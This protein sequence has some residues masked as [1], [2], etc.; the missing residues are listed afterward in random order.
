MTFLRLKTISIAFTLLLTGSLSAQG[1]LWKIVP[2]GETDAPISYLFGTIHT[3][4]SKVFEFNQDVLSALEETDVF[5]P[6]IDP[7]SLKNPMLLMSKLIMEDGTTLKDL[8]NEDEYN[9]VKTFFKDSLNLPLVMVKKIQPAF[10]AAMVTERTL[11]DNS[12]MPA[13]DFWLHEQAKEQNKEVIALETLNEQIAAFS[14]IDYQSQADMLLE[15]VSNSDSRNKTKALLDAYIN[16][17]LE[18]LKRLSEEQS[19]DGENFEEVF[20]VKRNQN[21]AQRAQEIIKRGKSLFI[22]VGAAHLPGEN[23]LIEIFKGMGYTVEPVENR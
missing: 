22:A 9:T 15:E 18:E 5:S 12:G 23:G 6:E 2:H 16:G 4:N 8:L 20:I 21:M 3:S 19:E 13:L 17:D 10:L 11:N 7:D 1:L 14:S